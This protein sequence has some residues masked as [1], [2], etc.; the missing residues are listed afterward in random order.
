MNI[1]DKN[2]E[3]ENEDSEIILKN[4]TISIKKENT[5]SYNDKIN[6]DNY[7]SNKNKEE[8]IL[9][10]NE[11]NES[12]INQY[13]KTSPNVSKSYQTNEMNLEEDD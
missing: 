1:K 7:I 6:N 3:E 10:E 12:K 13:I 4:S 2:N 9:F 8:N 5:I 11:N